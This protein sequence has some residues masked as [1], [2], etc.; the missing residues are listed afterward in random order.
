MNDHQVNHHQAVYGIYSS[1][2]QLRDATKSLRASGF[3]D[4]DVSVLLPDDS[5]NSELA[6]EKNTKAPEGAAVGG[7]SGAVLGGVLGWLAGAGVLVIP[8]IGPFIAAGP[9]LGMLSGAGAGGAVAGIAGALVGMGIPEYE[10]RR[11]ESRIKN[12]G[13][14]LSVH[15]EDDG[16]A[17]RATRILERTGAFDISSSGEVSGNYQSDRTEP[18]GLDWL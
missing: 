15:C 12:G 10:A 14:L 17:E 1:Q 4:N 16:W 2:L 9:I 18:P 6:V 13:I 11:F 8:G 7:A 5:E 3:R